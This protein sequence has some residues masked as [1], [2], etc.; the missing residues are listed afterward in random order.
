MTNKHKVIQ[1][2][3][4]DREDIYNTYSTDKTFSALSREF[5]YESI[6]HK[7]SYCFDWYNRP[8]IQ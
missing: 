5:F 1:E 2:F 3:Y 8:I 6:K 7:Y 4:K